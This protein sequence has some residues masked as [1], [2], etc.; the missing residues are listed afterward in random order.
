MNKSYSNL[1]NLTGIYVE[2]WLDERNPVVVN[3]LIGV[4]GQSAGLKTKSRYAIAKG[5]EHIYSTQSSKYVFPLSFSE[6]I[7]AH[8]VVNSK[9]N[10]NINGLCSPAGSYWTIKNWLENQACN[11]MPAPVGD[12]IYAFDN[13]QV[14]GKI[15]HVRANKKLKTSVITSVCMAEV[16]P[17]GTLQKDKTLKPSVWTAAEFQNAEILDYGSQHHRSLSDVHYQELCQSLAYRIDKVYKETDVGED[18]TSSD[19]VDKLVA[20]YKFA[21]KWKVCQYCNRRNPKSKR[22]CEGC[23]ASL[24]TKEQQEKPDDG[25]R[26]PRRVQKE[27]F[28]EV[29]FACEGSES[30]F[31][32][33]E[34]PV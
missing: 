5:V 8:S 21:Q 1:D 27:K 16:E 14:I 34:T 32:G 10:A 22:L 20:E 4:A 3:F 25:I 33:S 2:Q 18:G 29:D 12:L 15:Y 13:D 19:K 9:L 17:T 30:A 6:N 11:E 26:L 28:T 7:V 23:K 31:K 24:K